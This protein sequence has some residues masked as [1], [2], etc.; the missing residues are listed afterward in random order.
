[1]L[2]YKKK[3]V[4]NI[5]IN[6]LKIEG[7]EKIK[8]NIISK[9]D[10]DMYDLGVYNGVEMCL[11]CLENRDPEYLYNIGVNDS[12]ETEHEERT[13]GRTKIKELVKHG[14]A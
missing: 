12:Y 10:R 5:W 6:R 3:E 4:I 13:K 2:K 11:S 9:P 8:D 1:M 14:G 7:L